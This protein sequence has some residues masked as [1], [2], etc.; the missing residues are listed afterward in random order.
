[1]LLVRSSKKLKSLPPNPQYDAQLAELYKLEFTGMKLGLDNIRELLTF[2][3]N[4]QKRFATIHIAGSNGKGSV[5]AMLAAALQSCGFRTGLYTSPHLV[6]FRERIKIDGELIPEDVVAD[7][8]GYMWPTVE[9]LK[10][11]F[12]E[13]TT[14]LAFRYFAS[15]P[16]DV[17]VIET[18]LGGRL[19]ATN[20]LEHPLATVVTSISLEHTQFLGNTLEQIAGEKAGIFKKRSPAVVNV[21]QSLR[22]VFIAKAK[23]VGT[24][25]LFADEFEIPSEYADIQLPLLGSHQRQNLRTVLA[26]LSML[27]YTFDPDRIKE[28]I[29]QTVKLTGVRARLEEYPDEQFVHKGVKLILDVAHNPDAFRALKDY[30]VGRRLKPVVI[31]G[32][33]KDK[34]IKTILGYVRD[35]A[36]RIIA[37]EAQTQRALPSSVIVDEAKVLGIESVDGGE[38]RDGMKLAL[39]TLRAGETALLTGSHFVVGDYLTENS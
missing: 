38:V 27:D 34:D 20:I 16:V 32:L 2:L 15:S 4:P 10:A 17:A 24:S 23:E 21:D 13:V 11:T 14:A 31:L 35:F 9:H 33:A 3:A 8:L 1:M 29:E 19:D 36:S 25:V 18:G 39:S 12:F 22:P 30:F 7:L 26:T 28:G 37:V 6:D 5:S